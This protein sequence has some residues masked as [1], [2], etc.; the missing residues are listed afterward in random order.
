MIDTTVIWSAA[1]TFFLGLVSWALKGFAGEI[2]RL[3]ELLSRTREEV[4]KE[5]VA[6]NEMHAEINRLLTRLDSID[7]KLD[8]FLDRSKRS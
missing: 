6:K 5:Y 7:S 3:G 1:L 2:Q 8:S 4:A